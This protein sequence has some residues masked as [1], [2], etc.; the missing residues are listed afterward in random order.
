[1]R[2]D[3]NVV[4]IFPQSQKF[5]KLKLFVQRLKI[6]GIILKMKNKIKNLIKYNG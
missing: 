1:M 3:Q 4:R 2:I 5:S 6:V